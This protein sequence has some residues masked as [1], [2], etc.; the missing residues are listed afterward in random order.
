[1]RIPSLVAGMIIRMAVTIKIRAIR[2][3][4]S[5]EKNLLEFIRFTP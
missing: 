1:M 5:M 2:I 3:W 4:N